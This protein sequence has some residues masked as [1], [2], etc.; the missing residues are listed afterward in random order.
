MEE[1]VKK[2]KIQRRS[3]REIKDDLIKIK[4][5]DYNSLV[6]QYMRSMV[7]DPQFKDHYVMRLKELNHQIG[8]LLE[9]Y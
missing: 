6:S 5:F 1:V 7:N 2:E 3:P 4:L 8:L 9:Q